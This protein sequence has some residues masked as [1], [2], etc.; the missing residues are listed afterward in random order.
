MTRQ[1]TKPTA[2]E[3][4]SLVDVKVVARML[5]CS[6]KHVTRLRDAGQMPGAVKLGGLA[7]WRREAVEQWIADGCPAPAVG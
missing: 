3:R 5:G 2:D 1:A 6:T 7:R 4:P